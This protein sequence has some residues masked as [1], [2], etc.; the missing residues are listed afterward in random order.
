MKSVLIN[1]A[2]AMA[3]FCGCGNSTSSSEAEHEHSLPA[4]AQSGEA[5]DADEHT[6]KE[7]H[8]TNHKV[9]TAINK[10]DSILNKLQ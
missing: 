8:E 5:T 10:A 2:V 4:Q 3:L 1:C 7:I 9:E 6:M